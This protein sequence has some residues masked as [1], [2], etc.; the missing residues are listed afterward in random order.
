MSRASGKWQWLAAVAVGAYVVV[1]SP[2]AV[3]GQG[4]IPAPSKTLVV[5]DDSIIRQ[6]HRGGPV[7]VNDMI[8][9][10]LHDYATKK[11]SFS[12]PE[13][14]L[15][16]LELDPADPNKRSFTITFDKVGKFY[17]RCSVT[18][19]S[20][21]VKVGER[22]PTAEPSTTS[23]TARPATTTTLRPAPSTST[24]T[25]RPAVTAAPS[26][27]QAPVV[28]AA[29]TPTTTSTTPPRAPTSADEV[30]AADAEVAELAFEE[31]S[32][33]EQDRRKRTAMLFIAIGLAAALLGAGGWAWY[34]RPSRYLSA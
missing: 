23:S 11:H 15:F 27:L 26:T 5:T 1:G 7:V 33:Q 29:A 3:A 4:G 18:G 10:V 16:D 14:G 20:G 2:G 32:H 13:L 24:T 9:Y 12:Y 25:A 21:Y 8:T 6:Q 17:S 30:R 19:L 34:H 28:P 22:V 31:A